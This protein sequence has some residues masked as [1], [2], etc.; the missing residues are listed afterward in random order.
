MDF[1]ITP[2]QL[3][4]IAEKAEHSQGSAIAGT[5]GTPSQRSMVASA[6]ASRKSRQ[7]ENRNSINS[8]RK[9]NRNAKK[10][11][12]NFFVGSGMNANRFNPSRAMLGSQSFVHPGGA[13]SMINQKIRGVGKKGQANMSSMSRA[14]VLSAMSVGTFFHLVNQ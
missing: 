5:G 2:H 7:D 13:K 14:S 9:S 1:A 3:K 6:K 4:P 8:S 10:N 12:T 11:L